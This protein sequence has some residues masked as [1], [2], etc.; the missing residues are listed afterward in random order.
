M[1]RFFTPSAARRQALIDQVEAGELSADDL[2]MDVLTVLLRDEDNLQ[3]VR[4]MVMRETAFYFLAGAHT[5]VHS[6]G[7]AV[8]HLLS[9][10][11]A[12][13]DARQALIADRALVQRFVHE[14]FRLHPSSPVSK[15]RALA[16]LELPDGQH[17][18]PDDIVI[19]NL[20]AANRDHDVFGVD[21]EAFD[22][23]REIERGVCRN[24]HHVWYRHPCVPG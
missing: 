11:E 3:L 6:L 21:P 17:A 5:S 15:R 2:P 14:S 16:A 18:Q 7:H 9:W 1:R 19:V 20:R 10:C 23:Y 13:P 4:D 8:H 24:R 12:H 22:P